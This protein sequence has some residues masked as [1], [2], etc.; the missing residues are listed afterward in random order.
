MSEKANI[1]L[2]NL[3]V[4]ID[5][6]EEEDDLN[7]VD[8]N[9]LHP[10]EGQSDDPVTTTNTI[11]KPCCLTRMCCRLLILIIVM[12]IG[13]SVALYVFSSGDLYD[14]SWN[15]SVCKDSYS[16][17]KIKE[18]WYNNHIVINNAEK[19]KAVL[20]ARKLYNKH[21]QEQIIFGTFLWYLSACVCVII[22]LKIVRYKVWSWFKSLF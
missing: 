16:C 19:M 2:N 10:R 8:L 12:T 4:E 7:S 20:E 6:K 3:T 13:L 15:D 17:T 9:I 11:T 1:E 18:E 21:G 14:E 22:I 5:N